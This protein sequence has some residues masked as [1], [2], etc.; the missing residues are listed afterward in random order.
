[1]RQV[2]AQ[3]WHGRVLGGALA[4]SLLGASAGPASADAA[5]ARLSGTVR[6]VDGSPLADARVALDGAPPVASDRAGAFT[7]DAPPGRHRLTVAAD[8]YVPLVRLVDLPAS[9]AMLE[10]A[11]EPAAR[12]VEEVVVASVRAAADA[13]TAASEIA[14]IGLE[15]ANYGQE[16]PFLLAATPSISSYSET[17]LQLGGGYAYFTLRGLPQSRINMT[18]DGVPLNDPEESAVYF[19]NFGDFASALSSVRVERGAGSSALGSA[20]YGGAVRFESVA[21][22][23]ARST[24]VEAAGGSYDTAHASAAWQ[25]GRLASGLALFGRASWQETDG[26]R[27]RSGVEQRTLYA[28]ADWRGERTYVKAFGFTGREETQLAFLA[29]EPWILAENPRYNPMQP[30][31]TDSFGQ[32]LFYVQVARTLPGDAEIAGQLYY[33][34]AQGSLELYD[35][36]AARTGL[37]EYGIDGRSLGALLSGRARGSGW[38]LDLGLHALD[39]ER[40]HYA[41]AESGARLYENTGHK[42]ELSGFAKLAR[43]LAPR[44]RLFGDLE[45]RTAEFYYDGSVDLGPVDW[46]FV[47]PRLGIRWTASDRWA[48]W[49]SI[50]RS[51]REPARNDLLEGQDDLPVAIDLE[52]VRPEEVL[53]LELGFEATTLRGTLAVTLYDLEFEDEIAAT[54]EQSDLGYAIRRNLPESSRRGIELEAV[55][56]PTPR[57]RLAAVANLSRNRVEVWRQAVDVYDEHGYAGYRIVTVTDTPTA[58]SPETIVGASVDLLALPGFELALAGRWVDRAYLDNLGDRRRTTPSYSWFDFAARL[59]LGRW[60]ATGSPALTLRINNLLDE[61][62]A[63][64]SGYSYPYFVRDAAGDRLEGTPYFYP[65]APR[66]AVASLEL[67]F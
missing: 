66:H 2:R 33:S 17:G 53:D 19:A 43:D 63:W 50:G 8:G 7:F 56:R 48:L 25:S 62:R 67:R 59:E 41:F 22:A 21:L 55:L 9:G 60:I 44:W 11:L 12:F 27:E 51:E 42:R 23:E 45:L 37:T 18:L 49:A 36:P 46:T 35:D 4:L 58:L 32:D 3:R 6:A 52:R 20:A 16:M 34:G 47:N 1:M 65:L 39:F 13:P 54:G 61:D 28:G 14:G 30:G 40:D 57:W 29:V 15:R 38:R 64:P 26:W 31:E 5:L 10:L 24:E